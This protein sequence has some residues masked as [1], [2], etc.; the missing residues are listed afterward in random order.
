MR[1]VFAPDAGMMSHRSRCTKWRGCQNPSLSNK[2]KNARK[3]S[4]PTSDS[5]EMSPSASADPRYPTQLHAGA[6]GT[7]PEFGKGAVCIHHSVP[8]QTFVN[9]RSAR[10]VHQRQG[11]WLEAG[12]QRKDQV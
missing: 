8:Q 4:Q 7:G 5:G 3:M 11:R 2:L 9:K 10:A 1:I 6:V 12:N